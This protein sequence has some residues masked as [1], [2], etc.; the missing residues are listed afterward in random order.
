MM[1]LNDHEII[2]RV[3]C[4]NDWIRFSSVNHLIPIKFALSHILSNW[5]NESFI[6]N[7]LCS[8]FHLSRNTIEHNSGISYNVFDTLISY[9]SFCFPNTQASAFTRQRRLDLPAR[10]DDHAGRIRFPDRQ[11]L[12]E[13][14]HF[15]G[16]TRRGEDQGIHVFHE[17]VSGE[18]VVSQ[19]AIGQGV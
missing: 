1:P 10:I 15:D 17:P 3:M 9:Q 5:L 8:W 2:I 19:Q 11:A 6:D 14:R 12:L 7:P 18:A 16:H 13:G 4:Q